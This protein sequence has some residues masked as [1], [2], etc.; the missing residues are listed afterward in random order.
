MKAAEIAERFK[1]RCSAIGTLMTGTI[2]LTEAQA[3]ELETLETRH[4]DALKEKAKPLTEKMLERVHELLLI[5]NN[6][7]LPKTVQSYCLKWLKEQPEFYGR[8]IEFDN[9][10]TKKGR[11]VEDQ[12]LQMIEERFGLGM[13]LK[14]DK[15]MENDFLTGECDTKTKEMVI[16][17]KSSWDINTFPLF[18]TELD[19]DYEWQGQ[20]YME[21]YGL[22]KCMVAYCLT[23]TP[24][25]LIDR[26]VHHRATKLGYDED[27]K[28]DLY[29]VVYKELTYDDIPLEKRVKAFQFEKRAEAMK[30]V[31]ERV[32]L[33]RDF[34]LNVLKDSN[35]FETVKF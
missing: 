6:P 29:E 16:D 19:S 20:G 4:K 23:D 7:V 33:A 10:Y 2:G 13:L 27:E 8:R 15:R 28:I 35:L 9:K 12:S 5:K 22:K 18:E 21:L 26:E 24:P 1:I 11:D 34:I 31:K 3:K 32:L 30:E 14:N 17:A 25:D